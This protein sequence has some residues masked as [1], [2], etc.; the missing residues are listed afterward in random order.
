MTTC[1]Y[2]SPLEL[3]RFLNIETTVPSREP[4][5]QARLKEYI[6]TGTAI[7]T[8][9][10]LA[11]GNVIDGTCLIYISNSTGTALLSGTART[12]NNDSGI[13]TLD[14]IVGT[15]NVGTS[16]LYA[17]YSYSALGITNTQL[18]DSLNRSQSEIDEITLSHWAN[19]ATA[20]PDYTQVTNEKHS[21]KG[22]YDRAY[23]LRHYPLPDVSTTLVGTVTA[24]TSIIVVSSTDGFPASG[25]FAVDGDKIA[26]TSKNS[27]GTAFIGCTDV[28]AHNADLAVYPFV[29]EM[30]TTDSGSEP[31]WSVLKPD[32]DY[33][34]DIDT[35]RLTLNV[36]EYDNVYSS[37]MYPPN[38]I[39][40]RFRA[41]YVYGYDTIFERVKSLCLLVAAKDMLLTTGNR[42]M[43]GGLNFDN[44]Q[45]ITINDKHIEELYEILA[46]PLIRNI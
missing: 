16:T 19:G 33:D 17:T 3:A 43:I 13:V 18:Q 42:T 37:R 4:A 25:Y 5:G 22:R 38:L 34:L 41:T 40:N 27:P 9:F 26:Y 14:P 21:G 36:L 11:Y 28:S 23:Y 1:T 29:F 7:S 30:S 8:E 44:A 2:V 46:N 12:I 20:T 32:T 10:Y 15:A 35:G 24:G 6:G 39:P 45:N 31:T